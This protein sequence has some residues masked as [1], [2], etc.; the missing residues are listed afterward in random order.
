[1][2][3]SR[4]GSRLTLW[5]F[6]QPTDF[7]LETFTLSEVFATPELVSSLSSYSESR[8]K[9]LANREP[10]S[11][12]SGEVKA[13]VLFLRIISAADYY[14][15]NKT[16]MQHVPP[17]DADIILDPFLLN[18]LP[19][20]LLPTGVYL[21]ALAVVAWY[22]SDYVWHI[23]SSIATSNGGTETKKYQ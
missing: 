15:T 20:S 23:L 2:Y 21:L 17:V 9:T 13:S 18:V 22:T 1:M 11:S 19:R 3:G 8:Q 12:M 4:C 16:L 10:S 7:L 5:I 6:Q 14:T